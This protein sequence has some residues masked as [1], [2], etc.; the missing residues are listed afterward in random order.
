LARKIKVELELIVGSVGGEDKED[1][2]VSQSVV[3]VA[4][5]GE[6]GKPL[7]RILERTYPC[8]GIDVAP[9]DIEC[10]CS[11]LHVCYPFQVKDFVG[12]TVRYV[13]KYK[14]EL[15]IIHSTVSVG[16]TTRV[17]DRVRVPVAYSPIRGKHARMEQDLLHYQKFIGADNRQTLEQATQHLSAAGFRVA[18]FLNAETAE[19][20]KLLETTWL[21]VLVGWAQDVERMA[22][23]YGASYEEVD[24]FVEEISYLPRVFPGFIG[25]HCVMPN[26]AILRDRFSS[27]FL[28]AVVESNESKEQESLIAAGPKP[29]P[30]A[31]LAQ[32]VKNK[33]PIKPRK[34]LE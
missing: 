12:V 34:L 24:R 21:G 30:D 25:G 3:V 2:T 19:L 32:P 6:V 28:D 9:V 22:A 26:I 15:V 8:L 17:R 20:S 1:N 4:G 23:E 33:F 18:G 14:P 13:E 27:R 10:P 5:L 11:V 31:I 29:I 7:L 16:T